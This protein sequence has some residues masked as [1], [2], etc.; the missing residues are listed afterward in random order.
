MNHALT[1]L[2][3][4]PVFVESD[5]A[6]LVVDGDLVIRAVNPAYLQATIRSKDELVG[7]PMFE[8]FPDNPDDPNADGV[9]K[10]SASFQLVFSRS[11]RDR[12]ALQ[13]YDIR[14][15]DPRDGFLRRF[16]H[17]V[18]SPL[19]DE[20]GR[21][22]GALHHVEDVT[23]V[24]E[25]LLAGQDRLPGHIPQPLWESTVTALARE[26]LAHVQTRTERDQLRQALDSRIVLE[27]AKGVIMAVRHCSPDEAFERLRHWSRS[28]N[29]RIH[30]VAREVIRRATTQAPAP[31]PAAGPGA[32]FA[33]GSS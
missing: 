19:H 13:R 1:R 4:H 30:D 18:N 23:E 2:G 15:H 6:L 10:L 12:M 33:H 9:A 27:Q 20:R 28:S 16:W 11:T 31:A 7:V 14:A 29:R 3:D 26:T 22:L 8:A 25:P 5:A 21:T 24:L 32:A 17:P